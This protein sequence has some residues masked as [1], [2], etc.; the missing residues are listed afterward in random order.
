MPLPCPRCLMGSDCSSCGRGSTSYGVTRYPPV[1][2]GEV[3]VT[4]SLTKESKDDGED[5]WGWVLEAASYRE[6]DFQAVTSRA[7]SLNFLS[8]YVIG[9][10]V[11]P[12]QMTLPDDFMQDIAERVARI[13]LATDGR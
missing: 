13:R 11:Q 5:A 7:A 12:P 2:T 3:K 4:R 1:T 10:A 6:V 9:A 8:N